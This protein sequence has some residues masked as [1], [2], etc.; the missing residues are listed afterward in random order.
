[1]VLYRG[2]AWQT[3]TYGG[4]ALPMKMEGARKGAKKSYSTGEG[5]GGCQGHDD[6]DDR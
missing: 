3:R 5:E 6:L 4:D 1:M 2:S